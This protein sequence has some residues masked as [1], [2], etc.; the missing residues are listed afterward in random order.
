[1]ILSTVR[2]CPRSEIDRKPTKSWQKKYLGFVTDPNQV[3]VGITRAQEGLCIVGGSAGSVP[4]PAGEQDAWM[5]GWRSKSVQL[6][7]SLYSSALRLA[8]VLKRGS[9]GNLHKADIVCVIISLCYN[10]FFSPSDS[11]H[12]VSITRMLELSPNRIWLLIFLPITQT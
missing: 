4:R 8:V 2:S 1:M 9:V 12:I 6:M 3:N 5:K 11:D 7:A 10:Q